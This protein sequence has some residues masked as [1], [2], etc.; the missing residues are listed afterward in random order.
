MI[1]IGTAGIPGCCK[2][3]NSIEGIK[4]ISNLGLN[5]ME[6][7]FVRGV[8]MNLDMAKKLGETAKKYNVKLSIHAPYYINLCSEDKSKIQASKKRIID[9]CERAS[10]MNAD[11]VVFHPAYYGKLT[12]EQ[13]FEKVEQ[14]CNNMLDMLKKKKIDNVYLGLETTGKLSQFGTLDEIIKLCKRNKKCRPVIDFAHIYAR[15]GGNINFYEIFDKLKTLRLK[16][17]HSHFSGINYSLV[18]KGKGNEKNHL[19]LDQCKIDY[20]KL[21]DIIKKKRINITL[22]SESPILEIDALKMK[23]YLNL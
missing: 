15:Q 5:A 21:A 14:E 16:H 20:K 7:E 2:G 22:I 8:K 17:I 12:P 3:C 4:T 19:P 13:A 11:I 10:K 9:S 6:V 18:E 23:K 1:Y